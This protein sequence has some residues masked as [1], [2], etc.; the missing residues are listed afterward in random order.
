VG[1]NIIPWA[2]FTFI[3]DVTVTVTGIPP[4]YQYGYGGIAFLIPGTTE[5]ALGGGSEGLAADGA[6]IN[7]SATFTLRGVVTG[8]YDVVFYIHGE[9][10]ED[11]ILGIYT[12]SARNITASNNI[13]FDQFAVLPPS[14]TIPDIAKHNPSRKR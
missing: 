1:A 12:V 5:I 2:T 14:V 3:P 10:S 8:T 11:A 9:G 6:P 7:A 13:S 4:R